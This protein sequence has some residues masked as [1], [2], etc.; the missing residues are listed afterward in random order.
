MRRTI[1]QAVT[2]ANSRR[3][4]NMKHLGYVSSHHVLKHHRHLPSAR[5]P[6]PITPPQTQGSKSWFH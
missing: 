1:S 6:T 3:A 2:L 5:T 4:W